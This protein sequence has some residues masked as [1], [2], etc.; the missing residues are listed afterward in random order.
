MM[1]LVFK[2]MTVPLAFVLFSCES[3]EP[4]PQNSVDNAN[5]K[6]NNV[7]V[8]VK[9]LDAEAQTKS[10]ETADNTTA[11]AKTLDVKTVESKKKTAPVAI[12][13]TL[14]DDLLTV[15]VNLQKPVKDLKI[16]ANPL[17]GLLIETPSALDKDSYDEPMTLTL[18]VKLKNQIGRL[19]I[20]VSGTF[21][22]IR[23]AGGQTY[24]FPGSTPASKK[25]SEGVRD[26]NG[27]LIRVMP[28]TEK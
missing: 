14:K 26:G 9:K 10:E 4:K 17:E 3:S 24:D 28:A 8:N 11:T 5:R 2:M 15:T 7:D 18:P 21:D 13:F 27:D 12:S 16:Q 23:S 20:Y 1:K 6:M 22:G 19:A 25:S